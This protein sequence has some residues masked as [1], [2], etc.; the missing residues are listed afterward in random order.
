MKKLNT[1]TLSSILLTLVALALVFL[2]HSFDPP[3]FNNLRNLVFDNF[4]TLKPRTNKDS[5]VVIIDVDEPSLQT[6]GQWPWP[7]TKIKQI[8]ELT[9]GAG[10]FAIGFDIIFSEKDR[11]DARQLIENLPQEKRAEYQQLIKQ[12]PEND[13]ELAKAMGE[14][15]IV[16]G[17]ADGAGD[18]TNALN[19][20]AGVTWL[21]KDLTTAI[22]PLSSVIAPLP[23]L[24]AQAAGSAVIILSKDQTDDKIRTV[25][26]F[27]NHNAKA[28]P[29]L[30]IE[31]L[32][33][34]LESATGEP[35]NYV[36]K[37]SHASG[38]VSAGIDAISE[39]K[40]GNFEF[41]TTYDGQFRVYY[42]ATNEIQTV[43]VTDLL[44]HSEEKLR[45]IFEG[46]IV[47]F[48]VSAT[49]LRDIRTTTIGQRVPGVNIHAQILDQIMQG[50][51]LYRPDWAL[52]FERIAMVIISLLVILALTFWGPITSAVFGA[53]L[54]AS[55]VFGS[56]IAF[57]K[58]GYLIDPV[59][60]ALLSLLLYGLLTALLF[61]FA[62]REKK[63]IRNAF[64]HY[65]APNL[66][67]KLEESPDALKL[68]GEIKTLSLMFMDIRGFTKISERLNPQELVAF[69]NELMSPLSQAIQNQEGTIDKFIGDSIM[70]FWNAP[71]EVDAHAKKSCLAALEMLALLETMNRTNRFGFKQY[72]L[73]DVGIGIGINTGEGCVG[74][75]GSTSRFDYS[76]VG[77]TVNIAAR[78]EAATKDVGWPI[79][80]STA[81]KN[82]CPELAYIHAG[83]IQ[84][85][86]KS[87]A[88][89][90]YALVGDERFQ[91]SS[92]YKKL[93]H[94]Q[95]EI[96]QL[97]K[98]YS[99]KKRT[100]VQNKRFDTLV[101]QVPDKYA[102]LFN[103]LC[104]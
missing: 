33:V 87:K 103:F 51:F 91:Q 61:A 75:M 12:L 94:T 66:L 9:S 101:A 84:L 77:D 63:F 46:K 45:E 102:N 44:S 43:S 81:T 13:A 85:K 52:G 27:A 42:S 49:G 19:K 25:P 100:N 96:Q 95:L 6:L 98:K 55:I 76:V 17:A 57:S 7:R 78:L 3:S 2:A 53:G 11:T 99:G 58:Y 10:A 21:G 68:G 32:R 31:T 4:Q 36:I 82:N 72:G 69:L 86:G 67:S 34:A 73:S 29:T 48:G 14:A 35:Q 28:V 18:T 15:N 64:Q 39:V 30:S 56:W 74:N 62:D 92:D 38:E 8:I 22:T 60:P 90:I 24:Q 89:S 23:E 79:L 16:L 104:K 70:A 1:K 40:L 5:A 80:V 97:H 26:L 88:Q 20:Y 54:A 93:Q 37:T 65:L 83:K 59:I 47:L 41:P 71:I 50:Q